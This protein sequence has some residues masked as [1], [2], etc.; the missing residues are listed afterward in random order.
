[1]IHEE[2]N[3]TCRGQVDAKPRAEA[4]TAESGE[5]KRHGAELGGNRRPA[6]AQQ[7]RGFP[8]S[9]TV[10][11]L[12]VLSRPDPP[13]TPWIRSFRALHRE[14]CL[15]V[16]AE[17][18]LR[19]VVAEHMW[20]PRRGQVPGW[21][22]DVL[23]LPPLGRGGGAS[24]RPTS[25]PAPAGWP[26]TGGPGCSTPCRRTLPGSEGRQDRLLLPARG[27][28]QS[29][30]RLARVTVPGLCDPRASSQLRLADQTALTTGP[31]TAG[32]LTPGG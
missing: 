10:A 32:P 6:G 26:A 30:V 11:A 28:V 18:K 14:A 15:G 16:L 25:S 27:E 29:E 21:I 5:R 17:D 24:S 20:R 2:A 1:M 23:A 7:V 31:L 19:A 13:S 9:E 12:M 3:F 8:F 4:S 22:A